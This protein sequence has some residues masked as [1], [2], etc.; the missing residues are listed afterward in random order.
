MDLLMSAW[1]F[2]FGIIIGII[3][4]VAV[5]YRTAVTPLHQRIGKLISLPEQYRASLKHYPYNL[6]NFRY[7][8]DPVDGI[9]FEEDTI[10]FV[11]FKTGRMPRTPEQDHIKNLLKNGNVGWFE[12]TTK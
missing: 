6:D 2:L 10:L 11:R 1:V 3:V 9:Q 7:I 12:F 8:G 5:S 4:G